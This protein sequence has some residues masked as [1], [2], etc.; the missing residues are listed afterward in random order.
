MTSFPFLHKNNTMTTRNFVA[1]DLGA[2]SGRVI[3]ATVGDDG[4]RM[5][6]VHRFKTPLLNISGGYYWNIYT[7]YDE[8]IRGLGLI[9]NKGVKVESIGVDAWGVDVVGVAKDGTLC[10]LPR[11]YRDPYTQGIQPRFYK[12]MSREELYRRTGIQTLDINTVFQLYALH[13]EKASVL[14]NAR[15][16]LFIP[17]AISYLLTGQKYCEYSILSTSGLMDPVRK[18]VDSRILSVCKVKKS[19]FP[20]VVMPGKRIGKLTPATGRQTGLGQASV[21]AVAGHDTA[22]AVAAVPAADKGFAYLSSGTWSLMGIECSSPIITESTAKYNFT[23]EGG[24]GGTIT[25]LKN[26]T[27]LWLLEQCLLKWKL[28]DKDYSYEEVAEMAASCPESSHLIDVDDPAFASPTDMPSA[29]AEYCRSH[30]IPAPADEAHTIRLIYDSLAA[31]Y[32][33]TLS[34]LR[35]ISPEPIKT[36]HIIGGGSRNE[37]LNQLTADKCGIPVIAGPA[38]CT[39]IGNVMMQARTAGMLGDMQDARDYIRRSVTTK[40]YTP[41]L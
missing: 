16:L 37:L 19:R 30:G 11:S 4:M 25:L 2:T 15:H 39:A 35:E 6:C 21:I 7:I 10:G 3:L 24:A 12:K 31:K 14:D 9:G 20:A 33:K 18:R 17:D 38:E 26:I 34:E 23:N 32:A 8:V 1:V 36:L 28:E 5:E 13:R 41:S 29:I 40:M 22:S 27:G